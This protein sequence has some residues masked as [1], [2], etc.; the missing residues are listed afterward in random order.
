MPRYPNTDKEYLEKQAA[1]WKN[2]EKSWE[3][4][5]KDVYWDNF[6]QKMKEEE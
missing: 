4:K 5:K 2:I 6:I 1:I 3:P